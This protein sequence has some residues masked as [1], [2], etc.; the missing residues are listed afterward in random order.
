[1]KLTLLYLREVGVQSFYGHQ[2]QFE[3]KSNKPSCGFVTTMLLVNRIFPRG[4]DEP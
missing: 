3:K 4:G 2:S 1:M